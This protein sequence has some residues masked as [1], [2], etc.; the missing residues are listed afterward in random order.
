MCDLSADLMLLSRT[1]VFCCPYQAAL[2]GGGHVNIVRL[3][4][5]SIVEL[6]PGEPQEIYEQQLVL[7]TSTARCQ[8]W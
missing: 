4:G 7:R 8:M 3:D 2:S 6:V 1:D 5:D